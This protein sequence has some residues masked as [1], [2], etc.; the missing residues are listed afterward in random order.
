MQ[1]C[2]IC[3]VAVVA[4]Q[5]SRRRACARGP[6][7]R[8]GLPIRKPAPWNPA[9]WL[10]FGCKRPRQRPEEGALNYARNRP[11]IAVVYGGAG[12]GKTTTIERYA[13]ES[14]GVWVWE[15]SKSQRWSMLEALRAIE[16]IMRVGT[17][18][19]KS[20]AAPLSRMIV[21][22]LLWAPKPALLVV[23]EGAAFGA[24]RGGGAAIYAWAARAWG[25]Y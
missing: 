22:R 25:L 5:I 12:V 9:R 24:G 21:Q 1:G 6:F 8:P 4:R 19:K 11:S 2:R 7:W 17:G 23:D 20:A 16:E 13:R 18:A 15:A 10:R 14:A 3:A